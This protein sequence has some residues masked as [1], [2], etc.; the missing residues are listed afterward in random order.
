MNQNKNSLISSLNNNKFE[1]DKTLFE[2]YSDSLTLYYEKDEIPQV[3]VDYISG[4][5]DQYAIRRYEDIF[6]PK[7]LSEAINDECLYRKA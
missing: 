3:V 6:I 7:P 2:Y 1:N 4:M 5:T